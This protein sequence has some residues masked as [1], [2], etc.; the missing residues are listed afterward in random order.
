MKENTSNCESGKICLKEESKLKTVKEDTISKSNRVDSTSDDIETM[1]KRDQ[2]SIP[3]HR[4]SGARF[5]PNGN[6]L[7]IFDSVFVY[8]N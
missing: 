3:Y 7:G 6:I 2:V 8:S 1:Q 5:C 4:T